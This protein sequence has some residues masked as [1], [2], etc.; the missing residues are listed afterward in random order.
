PEGITQADRPRVLELAGKT[1]DFWRPRLTAAIHY[2]IGDFQKAAEYFNANDPGGAFLFL[3]ALTYHKLGD[4]NRAK[5]RLDEG[6]AWIREEQRATEPAAGTPRPH[7]WQE[8]AIGATWQY[9]ASELIQ[10]TA[11]EA[12]Q[13]PE[14]PV[15]EAQFQAALARHFA[16][17][18]QQSLAK[19][20]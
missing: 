16:E 7:A 14:R 8:W 12:N 1:D 4:A 2:R 11:V 5:Q 9:E 6:N 10:G 19:A 17:R 18:G 3:A 20:A 13:L 15:G